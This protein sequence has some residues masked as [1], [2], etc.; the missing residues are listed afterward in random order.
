MS[1][2]SATLDARRSAQISDRADGGGAVSG[3]PQMILRLEGAAVLIA[4][5]TF[6][7]YR[8]NDWPLFAVLFLV[9]DISILGYMAG[10]RVGAFTYNLGHSYLGPALLAA[11]GVLVSR[12]VAIDLA[13]IWIAHIGF[14]RLLGYGLKYATAF[15]HTH[16]GLKGGRSG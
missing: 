4:A 5:V 6:Y 9:P 14:D 8:S 13:L 1:V 2:Q 3:A 11:Y 12:Y 7:A 16:L 15:G 10:R